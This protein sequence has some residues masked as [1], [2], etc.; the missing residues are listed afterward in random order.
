MAGV[1]EMD[2]SVGGGGVVLETVSAAL[3][4]TPLS[5]ALIVA[6]PAATPVASP[7]ALMVATAVLEEV[8]A[9][10]E[11]RLAVVPSL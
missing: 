11:V 10:L 2:E 7:E 6:E 8:H 4:V 3:P 9:T 1:T 5:V